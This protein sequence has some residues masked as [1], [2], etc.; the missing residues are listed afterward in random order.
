MLPPSGL[1]TRCAR[2]LTTGNLA[3]ALAAGNHV[4]IPLLGV[5]GQLIRPPVK[6]LCELLCELHYEVVV[7]G[8]FSVLTPECGWA[9]SRVDLIRF[10]GAA[11]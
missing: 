9:V 5:H 2:W 8:Q 3:T 11:R 7:A 1:R 6:L 4:P 10:Y